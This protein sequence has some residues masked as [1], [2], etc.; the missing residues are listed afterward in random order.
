M[1][2][3]SKM[4]YEDFKRFVLTIVRYLSIFKRIINTLR[5]LIYMKF[6]YEIEEGPQWFHKGAHWLTL[7]GISVS[8]TR[9][10]ASE[11]WRTTRESSNQYL[12]ESNFID[13]FD[14]TEQELAMFELLYGTDSK[15]EY[16][17]WMNAVINHNKEKEDEKQS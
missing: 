17:K 6:K 3:L 2:K 11:A 4:F 14:P 5:V 13:P 10:I 16:L 15:E 8:Y 7:R 9:D 1:K 12:P